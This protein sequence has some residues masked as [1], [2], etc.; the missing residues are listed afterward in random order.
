[1]VQAERSFSEALPN[2][3][4]IRAVGTFRDYASRTEQERMSIKAQEVAMDR[5]LV[6]R[7]KNGDESAFSEMMER[8]WGRI[9]GLVNQMLR[10][11]QDA[12]EVTQDAFVRAHR[13]LANFRGESAF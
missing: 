8:Y 11:Q 10:N 5:M 4:E 9:Y 7:F 6:E 1:V 2:P 12:E 3:T 13:G